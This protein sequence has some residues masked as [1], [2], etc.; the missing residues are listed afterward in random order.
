MPS[1]EDVAGINSQFAATMLE[2]L[3]QNRGKSVPKWFQDFSGGQVQLTPDAEDMII[4][5]LSFNPLNRMTVEEALEHPYV[6]QFHDESDEPRC[7]RS[8]KLKID[9]NKRL[10]TKD[11]RDMLYDE[12][13]RKKRAKQAK[14]EA[15]R[16]G[17]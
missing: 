3:P 8:L 17:A 12:V 14:K 13:N 1:A 15:R 16:K 4:K 10:Q 11:Y 2:S 5:L 9:D 6:S 7:T